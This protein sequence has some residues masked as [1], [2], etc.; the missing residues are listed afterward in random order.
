MGRTRGAWRSVRFDAGAACGFVDPY[1]MI[2]KEDVMSLPV[3]ERMVV[4]MP[5]VV[6]GVVL[7]GGRAGLA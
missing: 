1:S 3:G 5:G 4:V 6:A 7:K 2:W